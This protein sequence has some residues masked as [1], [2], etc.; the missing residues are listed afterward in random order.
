[1]NVSERPA[2]RARKRSYAV[3]VL[4]L[5]GGTVDELART[6]GCGPAFTSYLLRGERLPPDNLAAGLAQLVGDE[7]ARAVLAAIPDRP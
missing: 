4:A 2:R 6:L 1:M 3:R 7:G 5:H